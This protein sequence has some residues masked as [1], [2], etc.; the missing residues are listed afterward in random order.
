LVGMWLS[1]S[2]FVVVNGQYPLDD[3]RRLR[4]QNIPV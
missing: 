2:K 3:H 1:C 4:D